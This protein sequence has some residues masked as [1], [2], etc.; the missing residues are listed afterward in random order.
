[1]HPCRMGGA[2]LLLLALA[3][4][5]G[6]QGSEFIRGDGNGDA[7]VNLAD[8][9]YGLEHLF[10]TGGAPCRDAMDANDDGLVNIA[11]AIFTVIY[12]FGGGP[13]LPGPF[14]DCGMDATTDALDCARSD[15]CSL[16]G[17][18]AGLSEAEL[19]SFARGKELFV[20]R[21]TR[22]EGTGPFFNTTSCVAC[23]ETPVVG[24]SAPN[25]R[26]FFLVGIGFP[27]AQFPIQNPL[28]PSLVLP[29]FSPPGQPRVAVPA[30]FAGLPITPAQRNAPPL[31]GVG[32]FEFVSNSEIISRA[33]PDDSM[34]PDGI[35]GRYNTDGFGNIGRFGYKLQANFLEAFLRGAAMN[36]MG[37]TTNPVLGSAG[38]VNLSSTSNLQVSSSLDDPTVDND[39]VPDPEM[40]VQEMADVIAFSRFLR[41]PT[42]KPFTSAALNGEVLFDTI[43]CTK[44]HVPTIASSVGPLNAYTDLLLHDMGPGLADGIS[45]GFP[46]PNLPEPFTTQNEF[47]TQPLWGVSLSG[48]FL[49]NGTAGTLHE[50]IVAHGGEAEAIKNVYVGL[51]QQE[52]DDIIQ[53][54]ESL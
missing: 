27:G 52:R 29:S 41:P 48:P 21:F 40:S 34:T 39:A 31:F 25:Y 3:A 45:Q 53:F 17:P 28:L 13:G 7:L 11:D 8:A 1:M 18:I 10:G 37:I 38:A 36:Q 2:A 9:L 15:A 24:G 4:P 50:A 30:D 12:L 19:E 44:C 54:L 46:Q 22:A 6:A 20:K 49:H 42:P 14:P 26:N 47:R 23:H 33:D 16:G 43:G 32:L 35:S 51:T 5:L